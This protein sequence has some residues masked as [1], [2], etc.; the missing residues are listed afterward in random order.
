MRFVLLT[1]WAIAASPQSASDLPVALVITN[2]GAE[3]VRAGERLPILA[4]PGDLLYPGDQVTGAATIVACQASVDFGKAARL[5]VERPNVCVLPPLA[6]NRPTTLSAGA[7][8]ATGLLNSDRIDAELDSER[9]ALP[10]S[11]LSTRLSPA[12][13]A[14][15]EALAG[16][17]FYA[18]VA[19]AE[20]L[21]SWDL[22]EDAAAAYREL[23]QAQPAAR[24]LAT[25]RLFVLEAAAAA[26]RRRQAPQDPTA[27]G[28]TYALLI[29]IS[30]FENAQI[31]PLRYSHRD[32]QVF[33]DLLLSA[34]GGGLKEENVLM[35][36]NKQATTQG[37]KAA[38]DLLMK[39]ATARDTVILL[40]AT[41]GAVIEHGRN[42]GAYMVTYDSDPEDLASTALPM[43]ALQ[44]FLRDDLGRAARVMAFVDACRA[45][46]IGTI[47]ESSK[48]RINSALD[49]LTQTE[50]QLMLFTASRPGE[51][52]Y[53]GRQYGGGHGA[54]SFFLMEGLN[55]AADLDQNGRVTLNEAV[56]YVQQRVAEATVDKQH[57]R[58]GGTLDMSVAVADMSRAGIRLGSFDASAKQDGESSRSLTSAPSPVRVLN[59]KAA[60]DFDQALSEGRIFPDEPGSA[61]A[62]FRQL[63]LARR[64][65]RAQL[66]SH[67]VR[68]RTALEDR[69]QQTLLKY[70]KGDQKPA[71]REDFE[72]G[73]RAVSAAIQVHGETPELAARLQF[74]EGR[75]AILNRDFKLARDLLEGA[76][77][78]NPD[79]A[80]IYNAL[81]TVYLETANY[82]R[83]EQ[84]FLSAI[85]RAELWAYPRHN[86]ALV[87]S[88]QGDY[89]RAIAT[90]KEAIVRGPSHAYL[91][92]NQA[93]LY[94]KIN[95]VKDAEAG[96]RQAMKL[97][98]ELPDPVTALAALESG[99]R[100]WKEAER[101]NREALKLKPDF[102]AARHNLG[103]LLE[104]DRRRLDEAVA[105]F[106]ENRR[107]DPRYLPSRLALA[108]VL[109]RKGAWD[110]ALAEYRE[111][112]GM[113]PES[114]FLGEKVDLLNRRLSLLERR[115]N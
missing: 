113:S 94:Q 53:E 86:L 16:S 20:K 109:E 98:P 15:F 10:M 96:F 44:R 89:E 76:L 8:V 38:F 63:K 55:G 72:A 6:R 26:A 3:I 2:S 22:A 91:V 66:V 106:E 60:V 64:L 34:R 54:F 28:T 115:R 80:Y 19:R 52:S 21:A 14:E 29:G 83:A 82:E 57:P 25:E 107:L 68:L 50:S 93:L 73:A 69:N 104:R 48:L 110:T 78:L 102:L 90:Y 62:A 12:Q 101:L 77:R 111:I 43:A 74:C 33:R 99:R 36:S 4:K 81:G 56:S 95:L 61:F 17:G 112:I 65:N 92:Y 70:L 59:L 97:A 42:R 40:F 105:C 11:Q 84:A 114:E 45:G 35:L 5:T 32:A 39:R 103:L 67:E 31:R 7:G 79:A 1:L 30:D 71:S 18:R 47:P 27:G 37:I 24:E 100:N 23:R 108:A 46:T 75:L 41:H 58:E 87:Y 13:R 9:S 88:Q 51:V 85:Q 49:S